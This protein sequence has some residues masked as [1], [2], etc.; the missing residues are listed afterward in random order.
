MTRLRISSPAR[1]DSAAHKRREKQNQE[2]EN[3]GWGNKAMWDMAR[4]KKAVRTAA[5]RAG[6]YRAQGSAIAA[7]GEPRAECVG[8]HQIASKST[9]FAA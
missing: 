5:T 6:E 7:L 2:C 1:T 4:G 8:P 9:R 3:Y